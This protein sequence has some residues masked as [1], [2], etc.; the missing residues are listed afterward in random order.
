MFNW[1]TVYMVLVSATYNKPRNEDTSST[2]QDSFYSPK[3]VCNRENTSLNH[4]AEDNFLVR[5]VVTVPRVSTIER[6]HCTFNEFEVIQTLA[7]QGSSKA[8]VVM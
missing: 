3:D 6:F 5:T 7:P 2:R 1:D 4:A 8:L